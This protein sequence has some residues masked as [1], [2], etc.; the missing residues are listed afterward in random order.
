MFVKNLREDIEKRINNDCMNFV[1]SKDSMHG[2]TVL[3]NALTIKSLSFIG[4][5]VRACARVSVDKYIRVFM[6]VYI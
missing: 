3:C 1:S 5:D 2:K 4:K 6:L